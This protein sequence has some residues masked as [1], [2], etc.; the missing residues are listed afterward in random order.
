MIA[1]TA[2][3]DAD[4]N[5][6]QTPDQ[7]T[8]T[9]TYDTRSTGT[10]PPPNTYYVYAYASDWSDAMEEAEELLRQPCTPWPP[11]SALGESDAGAKAPWLEAAGPV[12]NARHPGHGWPSLRGPP[13]I[14]HNATLL[15]LEVLHEKKVRS[16]GGLSARGNDG[17]KCENLYPTRLA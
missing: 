12:P 10:W 7:G 8:A 5:I 17:A 3:F 2:S 15:I 9:T 11:L 14:P 16:P 13:A 4:T 1:T 6:G